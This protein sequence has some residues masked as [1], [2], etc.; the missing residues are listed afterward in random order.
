MDERAARRSRTRRRSRHGE[1]RDREPHR[2]PATDASD[3]RGGRSR[4]RAAARQRRSLQRSLLPRPDDRA[5]RGRERSPA[6][7]RSIPATSSASRKESRKTVSRWRGSWCSA[8][9]GNASPAPSCRPMASPGATFSAIQEPPPPA[10]RSGPRRQSAAVE[11]A[12]NTLRIKEAQVFPGVCPYCAVGCAQ[13]IYVKDG[14]II[15]IEGDPDTPHTEG[16][17]CPKGSS[18]F[19]LSMNARRL[20]KALYRAPG[21]AAWEEKPLDW[22]MERIAKR[23]K[24]TRDATFVETVERRRHQRHG[25]PLR[26]DRLARLLRAR[27]RGELPDR[28]AGARPGT[29]QPR[30]LR[31][32]LPLGDGAGARRDVRPRGDDDEPDRR[33]QCRRDHADVELG[34]VPPGELSLGDEG[35]GA[36]REDHPRRSAVHAHV[37]DSRLLGSDPLGH[38]HRLLWRPD[39]LRDR[40]RQVL[41][42]LRRPLHQRRL[43][44]GPRLQD[45]GRPRRA[46]QRIR[47]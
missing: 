1:R 31:P 17:L 22:M 11:D 14:K 13:L 21:S 23:V 24:T 25:Q 7:T 6:S 10:P 34:R 37:G 18:T 16:A 43:P 46:V 33:R 44:D 35:Q 27:Q 19:Q 20:T 12:A 39:Q 28:Q 3:D 40:A 42:R 29:R 30:E 26:G 8:A 38:Q 9:S 32:P 47:S 4:T 36:G 45:A 15:D 2:S 5:H 41:P